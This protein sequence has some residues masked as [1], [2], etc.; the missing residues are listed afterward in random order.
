[1]DHHHRHHDFG[2]L[3]MASFHD[4]GPDWQ[5]IMEATYSAL[6]HELEKGNEKTV[7]QILSQLNTNEYRE[8]K[9]PVASKDLKLLMLLRKR[10]R[11]HKSQKKA[12]QK[13]KL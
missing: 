13:C 10:N 11:D 7:R 12:R 4:C 6:L 9:T 2:G 8:F 5:T 1:M 3:T